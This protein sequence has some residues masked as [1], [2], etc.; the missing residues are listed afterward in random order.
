MPFKLSFAGKVI[1]IGSISSSIQ[2]REFTFESSTCI[3]ALLIDGLSSH[4]EDAQ[5]G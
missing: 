1:E 3:W 5:L 2:Y 4:V